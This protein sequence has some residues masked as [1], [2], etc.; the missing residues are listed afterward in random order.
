MFYHTHK[1]SPRNPPARCPPPPGPDP[2]PSFLGLHFSSP[3]WRHSGTLWGG[4]KN[5]A[6]I[7]PKVNI[8]W[9]KTL[10][11]KRHVTW[12]QKLAKLI[13]LCPLRALL[14]VRKHATLC[15][16]H[17]FAFFVGNRLLTPKIDQKT[18]YSF[19]I[20]QTHFAR[21]LRDC[22]LGLDTHTV[23]SFLI[24]HSTI[25]FSSTT[26]TTASKKKRW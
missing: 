7:T 16:N 2:N 14:I 23:A 26:T 5:I 3:F 6:R 8:L 1:G 15:K 25:F 17:M 18:N 19:Q 21:P 9:P 22:L 13:V 24:S 20:I 11:E 10:S 4:G 12:C